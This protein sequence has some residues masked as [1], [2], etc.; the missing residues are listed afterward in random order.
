[1]ADAVAGGEGGAGFVRLL[2]RKNEKYAM[3]LL[4][5]ARRGLPWA[6]CAL[7]QDLQVFFAGKALISRDGV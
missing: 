2:F 4:I 3:L 7:E 6:A 1:L 5:V